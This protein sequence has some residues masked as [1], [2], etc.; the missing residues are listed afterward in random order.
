LRDRASLRIAAVITP[1]T[2]DEQAAHPT[3]A[4]TVRLVFEPRLANR[5][6]DRDERGQHVARAQRRR[7][8][9]LW[10][11][12]RARASGGRLRMAS[13]AAIEVEARPEPIADAVRLGE[14]LESAREERLLRCREAG[15]HCADA[16][17]AAANARIARDELSRRGAR[18]D[19][20]CHDQRRQHRHA[21]SHACLLRPRSITA[22]GRRDDGNVGA[23]PFSLVDSVLCARHPARST[24]AIARA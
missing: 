18:E 6:I 4:A 23:R 19:D 10:V 13:D 5:T 1:T 11:D 17:G 22:G 16:R 14:R 15:Q 2:D 7:D 8:L 24:S 12:R 21:R 20:Q 9:D 3:I